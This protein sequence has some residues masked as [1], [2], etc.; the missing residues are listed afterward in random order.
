[1][2]M[3]A[4]GGCRERKNSRRCAVMMPHTARV[5]HESRVITNQK[6]VTNDDDSHDASHVTSPT[7][8]HHHHRSVR[9]IAEEIN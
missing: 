5:T 8:R 1:M 2:T 6:K 7:T 4:R 3:A 9:A